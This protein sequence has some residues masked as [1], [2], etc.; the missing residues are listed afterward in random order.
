MKV[1]RSMRLS[2][3]E[4]SIVRFP[5]CFVASAGSG[6]ESTAVKYSNVPAAVVDQTLL[7]QG[8]RRPSD[9]D[10][11]DTKHESQV[12]LGNM[13]GVRVRAILRHQQPARKSCL[14]DVKARTGGSLR[15]LAHVNKGIAIDFALQR[16]TAFEFAA[17]RHR[18][19]S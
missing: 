13:E 9:P 1:L 2:L 16:R 11:A 3:G 15:E 14:D 8:S 10:A 12:F 7:L 18:V 6:S 4:Y 17:E 5:I 19:H